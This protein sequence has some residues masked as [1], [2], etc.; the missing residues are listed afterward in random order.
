MT[1]AMDSTDT[2][3]QPAEWTWI[4]TNASGVALGQATI[5]GVPASASDWIGAFDATGNC[6]GAAPMIMNEGLAVYG[7]S[8]GF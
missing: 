2:F 4:P 1:S 6:A 5:N 7:R 3:A 8:T